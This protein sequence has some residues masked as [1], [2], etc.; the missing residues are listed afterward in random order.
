MSLRFHAG[1]RN[2]ND[3]WTLDLSKGLS[4]NNAV[5]LSTHTC[6]YSSPF[7]QPVGASE[8]TMVTAP[9]TPNKRCGNCLGYLFYRWNQGCDEKMIVG[10]SNQAG[11][12]LAV[13]AVRGG[14]QVESAQPLLSLMLENENVSAPLATLCS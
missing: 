14:R 4:A 12:G 3:A 5:L 7:S 6:D 1:S 11:A 2:G 8:T 9:L 10:S 13:I